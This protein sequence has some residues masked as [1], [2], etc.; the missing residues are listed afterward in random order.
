MKQLNEQASMQLPSLFE[1]HIDTADGGLIEGWAWNASEPDSPLLLEVFDRKRILLTYVLC[2]QYRHDLLVS[3]KG[4]GGHGFRLNI[5]EDW[6]AL[7]PL[8][9]VVAGTSFELVGSPVKLSRFTRSKARRNDSTVIRTA[10]KGCEQDPLPEN[11]KLANDSLMQTR[12]IESW[13]DASEGRIN[14]VSRQILLRR[15][16]H[17]ANRQASRQ[18]IFESRSNDAI[19]WFGL[20]AWD[21]RNQRPQQLCEHLARQGADVFY[22]E[23]EFDAYDT[24]YEIIVSDQARKLFQIKLGLS[25]PHPH[26]ISR[27]LAI[28][29]AKHLA[30]QVVELVSALRKANPHRRIAAVINCPFWTPV[31][32]QTRNHFQTTI[33]DCMDFYE[34]FSGYS[35]NFVKLENSLLRLVDFVT[36]SSTPI[37]A[38]IQRRNPSAAVFKLFNGWR[39]DLKFVRPSKFFFGRRANPVFGYVGAIDE[40]FDVEYVTRLARHYSQCKFL[41]A[42]RASSGH[43]VLLDKERN[44]VLTGEIGV[45]ELNAFFSEIDIGLIPFARTPLT[46]F[47]QPVK[48]Y[49]YLKAERPVISTSFGEALSF[50]DIVYADEIDEAIRQIDSWIRNRSEMRGSVRRI[51]TEIAGHSWASRAST[52]LDLL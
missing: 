27:P 42:G 37:G 21:S 47:V 29:S 32:E 25:P 8:R 6:V 1:G 45:R 23:P 46:K 16:Y 15:E 5:S 20:I 50:N 38:L 19:L 48:A 7:S 51:K 17:Y 24:G 3:G 35:K 33:Y 44:I 41:I 49:E 39:D 43:S 14:E 13:I 52:L 10:S 12:N 2:D 4:A 18:D 22:I 40:W 31:I 28:S 11:D 36:V 26:P 9:I 30:S 34:G